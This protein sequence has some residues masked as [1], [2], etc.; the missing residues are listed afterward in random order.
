[1]AAR[2]RRA[3]GVGVAR[4]G[5]LG[6]KSLRTLLDHGRWT[7]VG[8]AGSLCRALPAG[9]ILLPAMLYVRGWPLMDVATMVPT[10]WALLRAFCASC[11]GARRARCFIAPRLSRRLGCF[12]SA[13]SRGIARAAGNAFLIFTGWVIGEIVLGLAGAFQFSSL[14]YRCLDKCRAPFSFLNEHW[15][16]ADVR[17]QSFKIGVHHGMFCVGCC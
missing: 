3:S 2:S 8:L 17:R 6:A 5:S 10:G 12:R 15:G 11:R 1:V 7:E 4:P 13:R 14:K 16:G 9:P